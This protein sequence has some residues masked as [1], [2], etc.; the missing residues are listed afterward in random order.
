MEPLK[1][2][3]DVAEIFGITRSEAFRMKK[4]QG[5]PCARFG[6]ELRFT[7]ADIEAIIQLNHR[8]P[9]KRANRDNQ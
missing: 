5:W 2:I 8:T 4:E 6:T 7:Q 3:G 9:P 1:S